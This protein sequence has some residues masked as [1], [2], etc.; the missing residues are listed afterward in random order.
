MILDIVFYVFAG[1]IAIQI[2]YYLG[3]FSRFAFAKKHQNKP[4]RIPISVIVCAKNEEDNVKK[5]IPILAEQDYP[6]YEIVL[7][8]DASSDDTLEIFK[9][10]AKQYQ[11]VKLVDVVNNEAFW[12]NKKYALT[13]G[14]K[15]A[16]NEYL[17][18]TDSNSYPISK[19]WIT[20]MS[21]CF[22]PTKTI[23]LGYGGYEK[24]RKSL[25]NLL[26]RFDVMFSTTQ[27]FAWAKAGKPFMGS[28]KNMA[29]KR[30]EFFKTNGFINHIQFRLG[31]DSLF[32][33][34]AATNK[35]TTI[36]FDSESFT[37]SKAK[38]TYKDWLKLK[39]NR[40][41]VI[42]Y[43]KGFDKFQLSL[44]QFSQFWFLILA[45][46][47]LAVGYNWIY[48][49][50]LIGFRYIISWLVIGFSA[51]KLKEKDTIYFY[52]FLEIVIIFIQANLFFVNLF[53]KPQTWK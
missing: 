4:K 28:G 2:L 26:I 13:L 43:F 52:P 31:E 47:L 7:I 30:E 3:I 21:A 48:L 37:Y 8:N 35:N 40:R 22:T 49:V 50:S 12:A 23:V 25:L 44:F 11:N 34:E 33:N 19:N 1:I 16:K 46:L 39:Q 51:S 32:I 15:A 29:Y 42:S 41:A 17:L 14:I 24:V 10:F 45:I 36:C 9:A 27:Y 20:Q 5:F 38:T 53:S 18:F 6:D